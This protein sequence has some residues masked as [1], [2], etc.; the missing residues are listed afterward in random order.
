MKK[1]QIRAMCFAASI[2]VIIAGF[3]R[4][5]TT[6]AD[7][8]IQVPNGADA[9]PA[10]GPDGTQAAPD[11]P[12]GI[13]GGDQGPFVHSETQ[14]NA[15]VVVKGGRGGNGQHGGNGYRGEPTGGKGG[16][17]GTGGKGSTI[18]VRV[19]GKN[20]TVLVENA[21]GGKGGNGGNGGS[22][23][24]AGGAGGMGGAAG[25][26][27]VVLQ[28]GGSISEANIEP[29]NHGASGLPGNDG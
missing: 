17:G 24:G 25:T 26:G 22:P 20:V 19:Y 11:A 27:T 12:A 16:K 5:T 9:N 3:Y 10:T 7:P 18:E 2:A 6:L 8:P 4:T 14:N 21:D 15:N 1:S 13:P 29:G 23:G 28:T